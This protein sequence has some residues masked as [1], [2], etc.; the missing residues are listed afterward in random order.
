MLWVPHWLI[1]WLI[2]WVSEWVSDWLNNS[3]YIAISNEF[4]KTLFFVKLA[5]L[6]FYRRIMQAS[7]L[8]QIKMPLWIK[9]I[10]ERVRHKPQIFWQFK[11]LTKVLNP[12]KN[13]AE[14]RDHICN[15][16]SEV[17]ILPK[18]GT[19]W[20]SIQLTFDRINNKYTHKGDQNNTKFTAA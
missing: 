12:Y 16:T 2:D 9:M 17:H 10:H 20:K 7:N 5:I 19:A 18:N 4:K 1:G 11:P 3:R 8:R 15:K 13:L 6:V 14:H